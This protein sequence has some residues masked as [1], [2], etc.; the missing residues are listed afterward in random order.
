MER[1]RIS[2]KTSAEIRA[3]YNVGIRGKQ[4]L[5]LFPNV[6]KSAIYNH[7]LRPLGEPLLDRRHQNKGRP[8]KLNERDKREILRQVPILREQCGSFTSKK[9]QLHSVGDRV[10]NRTVRR[11]LNKNGYGYRRARKKGLMSRKDLI[12][13][14]RFA[15]KVKRLLPENFWTT[16]ISFY[17][18]GVGFCYKTNPSNEAMAPKGMVWRKANEGLKQGCT[19]KGSKEGTKQAHFIAAISPGKG[20][21]CCE[22]YYDR[23]SGRLFADFVNEHFERVFQSSSNQGAKRF[24][25]DGC[26]S[27]N[28]KVASTAIDKSNAKLFSIPP[29]SPD[30]NPIENVFN[31]VKRQLQTDARDNKITKETF[32]EFSK[33]CK[34]TL[35]NFPMD[36]IDRTIASMDKRMTMIIRAK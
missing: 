3:H 27:Q 14:K 2:I 9:V 20:F 32:E 17:L 34:D 24:L 31:L 19:A 12:E 22:Q 21:V 29:R 30:I 4:L 1:N 13:R 15:A 5:D 25:Q 7:A 36:I 23:M 8:E 28:S 11:V 18:D 16:G 10:H 6:S 26:P 33:R 35:T